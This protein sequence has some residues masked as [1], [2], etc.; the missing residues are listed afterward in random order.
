ME[1][2]QIHK[3][4]TDYDEFITS[5]EIKEL[6]EGYETT[7]PKKSRVWEKSLHLAAFVVLADPNEN[8]GR[9]FKI[10]R[11]YKVDGIKMLKEVSIS[12]ILTAQPFRQVI[13]DD[14][15][16]QF[17]DKFFPK[18]EKVRLELANTETTVS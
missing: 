15:S 4:Y 14:K 17:T 12:S 11:W 1:T 8:Y 18:E 3:T 2:L 5:K 10:Y 16:I 9:P 7:L 6:F 13:I